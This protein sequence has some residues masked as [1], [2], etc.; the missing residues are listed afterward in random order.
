M[1][2]TFSVPREI[3]RQQNCFFTGTR[4]LYG[5][6]VTNITSISLHTA[7]VDQPIK[8]E[9]VF[10]TGKTPNQQLCL[11]KVGDDLDAINV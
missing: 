1:R 9:C 10:I 4:Q 3:K 8:A 5:G 7:F 11:Y 2:L 6:E